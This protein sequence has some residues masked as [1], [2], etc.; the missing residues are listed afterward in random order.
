MS[1]MIEKHCDN[2]SADSVS[3]VHQASALA[4]RLLLHVQS[5][6]YFKTSPPYF[7][8]RVNL[9][10]FLLLYSVRGQGTLTLKQG[11]TRLPPGS[12]AFL[13]CMDY[14]RYAAD[15]E[16]WDFYYI[17][18]TGS[19]ALDYHREFLRSGSISVVPGHP[20][21]VCRSMAGVIELQRQSS[22]EAE[23]QTHQLLTELLGE[24]LLSCP[25]PD[26]AAALPGYLQDILRELEQNPGAS[27]SLEELAQRYHISK[28]Y[29]SREF[30]RLVGMNLS[31][32]LTG[33]RLRT[34]R[35][36]LS[37]TDLSVQEIA[38]QCGFS[39]ASHFIRV[40]RTHE[41]GVTPLRYRRQWQ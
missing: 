9:D 4:E 24:L 6:G 16:G 27:L 29:L 12:C 17:H 26:A 10:S 14:H 8:E 19:N 33:K 34:A 32:Y 39:D 31:Q 21:L 13:H 36:L 15:E 23:M 40:F 11:V 7:A 25:S 20:E 30:K 2:W 22:A 37:F 3:V 35:Q 1:K 41:N 28:Y 18:F 5:A 38:R